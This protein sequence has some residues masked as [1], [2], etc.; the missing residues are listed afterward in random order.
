MKKEDYKNLISGL[1]LK[2]KEKL[3]EILKESIKE[4]KEQG[5]SDFVDILK[6][7]FTQQPE[8]RFVMLSSCG[9]GGYE[10]S[11]EISSGEVTDIWEVERFLE[12]DFEWGDYDIPPFFA[13]YGNNNQ[14]ILDAFIV[15]DR[16]AWKKL[17]KTKNIP[18]LLVDE[19]AIDLRCGEKLVQIYDNKTGEITCYCVQECY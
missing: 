8:K 6:S 3:L 7:F 9:K 2:E 16:N 14:K 10:C 5:L 12:G 17:E 18:A 1:T 13:E 11:G 15:L 4:E 19:D